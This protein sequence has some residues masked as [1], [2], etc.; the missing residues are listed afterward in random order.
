MMKKTH[1]LVTI[2]TCEI[3]FG[4]LTV[5]VT[6]HQISGVDLCDGVRVH[7][8]PDGWH[9]GHVVCLNRGALED[10]GLWEGAANVRDLFRQWFR[11]SWSGCFRG[12]GQ[13]QAWGRV[14]LS[15]CRKVTLDE[16]IEALV[17]LLSAFQFGDFSLQDLNSPLFTV[18]AE[19]TQRKQCN[20]GSKQIGPK[21]SHTVLLHFT[22]LLYFRL[23]TKARKKVILN[24]DNV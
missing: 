10:A 12:V 1:L 23:D 21:I 14:F 13:I 5:G 3:G 18:V 24:H 17:F 20:S 6:G 9:W 2:A 22:H 15:Q 7:E 11:F 19:E 8:V 4:P 16:V